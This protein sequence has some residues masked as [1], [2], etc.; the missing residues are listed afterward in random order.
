VHSRYERHIADLPW[1]GV[2]VTLHLLARRFRCLFT[3]C[4]RRIFCERLPFLVAAYARRTRPL[5]ALLQA[6]GFALG[7]RPACGSST[8]SSW[9]PVG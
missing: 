5:T 7:G 9:S 3:D 1:S 4:P 8:I 6:L 2:R